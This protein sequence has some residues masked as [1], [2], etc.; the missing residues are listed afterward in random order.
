MKHWCWA[1][2]AG[3]SCLALITAAAP[4][5]AMMIA[6][7]P[8]AQRVALAQVVIVGKVTAF[9]DKTVPALPSPGATKKEEYQVATVQVEDAFQGAKDAKEIQVGFIP[10]AAPVGG[11]GRVFPGGRRPGVNLQ[12]D[13][14]YL[15]FVNPHD[16]APFYVAQAYFDAV[17][18][19]NNAN[20]DK[21]VDEA[22][23]CAKLLADPK[24][25]L[26]SDKADDRALTAEMLVA[27]YRL[28]RP[29]LDPGKTEAIDAEESKLILQALA[30][31]DWKPKLGVGFQM[32]P[33]QA[34]LQLGL[35]DKDGWT[36]PKDFNQLPDAAKAWLKDNADKYRIQRFVPEKKE[37][38][39]KDGK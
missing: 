14:E 17:G 34:F 10:P 15:L 9:A 27:R 36:Q 39:K 18:K 25:G 30:D 21:D 23:R 22:K 28:P 24:A 5:K 29:G 20:F 16:D 4:A 7:A 1:G 6:P 3:I 37:G 26:K 8:I 33:Q 38:E 11:P 31:A 12:V 32:A 19:Q 35:T 2:L 13:Q